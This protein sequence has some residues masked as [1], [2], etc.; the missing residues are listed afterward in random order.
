MLIIN[1]LGALLI[2][3]IVWWFWLYKPTGASEN[4]SDMLVTVKNGIYEPAR[5]RIP[6]GEATSIKF[7]REEASPCAGTVVFSDLEI[8]E[9]LPLNKQ[10]TIHLPALT[11]GTYSFTCQMQMYRGEL[12]VDD[13][14]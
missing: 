10:K 3:G 4:S 14:P 13:K 9:E 8:S 5:L 12:I 7:L 11:P 2:L 6:A 1:I